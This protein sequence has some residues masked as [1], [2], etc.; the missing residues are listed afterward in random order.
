MKKADLLRNY[1]S[2]WGMLFALVFPA[3]AVALAYHSLQ[4]D[5]E[6]YIL[7]PVLLVGY[8]IAM[9]L[10]LSI[11]EALNDI[12]GFIIGRKPLDTILKE[13]EDKEAEE[14]SE[15][16]KRIE[17]RLLFLV[18]LQKLAFWL[19][20]I[21]GVLY[22]FFGNPNKET[23]RGIGVIA[24]ALFFLW[25][26]QHIIE[27]VRKNIDFRLNLI[28]KQFHRIENFLGF[29][30]YENENIEERLSRPISYE[31]YLLLIPHWVDI[32]A[33]FAR[34]RK[35]SPDVLKKVFEG[36][37]LDFEQ[38]KALW[39]KDFRF[40]IFQNET[41]GM[42]QIWSDYHKKFVDSI[43]VNGEVFDPNDNLPELTNL[44]KEYINHEV[45]TGIECT[46]E[47]LSLEGDLFFKPVIL[48]KIPYR[49]ILKLLLNLAKYD[50]QGIDCAIKKFPEELKKEMDENSVQYD[51]DPW[52]FL[53]LLD[54]D[55]AQV[56]EDFDSNPHN[57]NNE[58]WFKKEGVQL[59]E[60]CI[61]WHA[62]HTPYYTASISLRIFTHATPRFT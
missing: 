1:Y 8:V 25:F 46:P 35:H 54:D 58:E 61:D 16:D 3:I 41:S 48:A 5:F 10:G 32:F 18:K 55:D 52:T 23:K 13:C 19:L 7:I 26:L 9:L 21:A 31:V 11:F 47:S 51:N 56:D 60:Q 14:K 33:E 22:W 17:K 15:K 24:G 27:S 59:Y 37:E 44:N 4:N 34:R 45:P 40:R 39:G 29:Y 38:R 20:V 6:W 12:V 36:G 49:R 28:V 62:F 57:L 50:D 2:R 42:K 30:G 53:H 43:I